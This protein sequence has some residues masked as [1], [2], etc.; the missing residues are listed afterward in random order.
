[1]RQFLIADA[2]SGVEVE[3]RGADYRYLVR[4]RRMAAGAALT[5]VDAAGARYQATVTE[6]TDRACNPHSQATA[7]FCAHS[8]SWHVF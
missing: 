2:R 4:V 1:M 3:L 6:V 5:V 7:M 8:A